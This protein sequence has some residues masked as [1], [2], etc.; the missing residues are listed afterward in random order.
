MLSH[1]AL[2]CLSPRRGLAANCLEEGLATEFARICMDRFGHGN[3]WH[4]DAEKYNN[5]MGDV[6]QL[7]AINPDVIRLARQNQTC[8]SLMT[9]EN[10]ED[11][12]G[13]DH[14][15]LVDRLVSAFI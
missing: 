2:H 5:A 4:S 1:E 15:E 14:R 3:T 11:I 12:I 7:L 10:L 9:R 8:L 13:Q 6:Q